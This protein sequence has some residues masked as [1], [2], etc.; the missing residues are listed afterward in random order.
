[1]RRAI[2]SSP[3]DNP[4]TPR[5]TS[6]LYDENAAAGEQWSKLQQ[7][8]E[9]ATANLPLRGQRIAFMQ[10]LQTE[11]GQPMTF[12]LSAANTKTVHWSSRLGWVAL[13]FLF[14]WGAVSVLSRRLQKNTCNSVKPDE[15]GAN[16]PRRAWA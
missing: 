2:P 7:A 11:A 5:Q 15:N 10:V 6:S 8:Q 1:M 4:G 3:R 9:I 13:A 16:G 14:L 12:L